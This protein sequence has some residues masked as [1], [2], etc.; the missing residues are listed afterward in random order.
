MAVK[1]DGDSESVNPTVRVPDGLFPTNLRHDVTKRGGEWGSVVDM[2]SL[3]TF[4]DTDLLELLRTDR[5]AALAQLAARYRLLVFG[6]AYGYTHELG[7]AGVVT[8]RVFS[9]LAQDAEVI[10]DRVPLYD[11]FRRAAADEC[12]PAERTKIC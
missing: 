9:R 1:E 11:W 2:T 3:E 6:V 8:D 7:R 5:D 10:R 4:S 12:E